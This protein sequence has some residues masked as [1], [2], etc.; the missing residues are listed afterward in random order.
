MGA[1]R[2]GPSA[3]YAPFSRELRIEQHAGVQD[4]GRVE[5]ALGAARSA[6]AKSV[7]ALAV[8]PGAVVAADGVVVRDRA[9]EPDQRLARGRL[10]LVPLLELGAARPG[11]STV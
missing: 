8:V 11:A 2:S 5:R 3:G 9:A 1:D 10:D 6:R 4:A 7:A